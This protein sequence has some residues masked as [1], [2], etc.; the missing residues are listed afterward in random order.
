MFRC[1][2]DDS[3]IFEQELED[4]K[5]DEEE[6]EDLEDDDDSDDSEEDL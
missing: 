3:D 2:D 5:E 6:F 4:W 1:I